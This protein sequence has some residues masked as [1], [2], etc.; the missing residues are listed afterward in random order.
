MFRRAPAKHLSTPLTPFL[1]LLSPL[2]PSPTVSTSVA[3]THPLPSAAEWRR[4]VDRL[5]R[6]STSRPT[7]NS[8]LES[9]T[10]AF[11]AALDGGFGALSLAQSRWDAN[12]VEGGQIGPSSSS[13]GVGSGTS[14]K[15]GEKGTGANSAGVTGTGSGDE[16]GIDARMALRKS[17]LDTVLTMRGLAEIEPLSVPFR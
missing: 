8:S 3:L 11:K 12:N 5:A 1:L 6:L 4:A 2:H 10:A 9:V 17:V 14:E 7:L 16:E 13:P 15:S